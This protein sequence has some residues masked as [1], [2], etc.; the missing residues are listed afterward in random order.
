MRVEISKS[1]SKGRVEISESASKGR[2]E[3]SESVSKGRVLVQNFLTIVPRSPFVELVS[4]L[5]I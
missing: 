4:S 5:S 3:K 2:V 1:V